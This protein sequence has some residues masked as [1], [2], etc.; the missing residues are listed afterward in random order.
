[1]ASNFESWMGIAEQWYS[2]GKGGG[3]G[4]GMGCEGGEEWGGKGKGAVE[5]ASFKPSTSRR[6][7]HGRSR[8]QD[9][10]SAEC[11]G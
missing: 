3:R 6:P 9:G 11:R 4:G 8:A 1:M 2:G 7:A 10:G 5:F